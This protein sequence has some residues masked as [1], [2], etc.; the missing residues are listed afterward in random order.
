MNAKLPLNVGRTHMGHQRAGRMGMAQ[1][2]RV[3]N[4][5]A[6]SLA[7]PL[8]QMLWTCVD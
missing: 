4:P 3:A 7:D 2:V 6:G 1:I 8:N 5:K